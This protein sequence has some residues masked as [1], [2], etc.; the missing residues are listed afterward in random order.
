MNWAVYCRFN[1]ARSIISSAVLRNLYPEATVISGGIQAGA[2][3]PIPS[4]VAAIA[5]VWGLKEFDRSSAL[6][7]HNWIEDKKPMVLVADALVMEEISRSVTPGQL[8]MLADFADH[9]FLVPI[10]PTGLEIDDLALE[11]SKVVVLTLRWALKQSRT[12]VQV[13]SHLVF[14][15][16][17]STNELGANDLADYEVL[18]DSNISRPQKKSWYSDREIIHFNP[19]NLNQT[20]FESIKDKSNIV[21]ASKFEID[22]CES[23]YLSR[24]W[25]NFLYEIAKVKSVTIVADGQSNPHVPIAASVLAISHSTDSYIW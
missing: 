3:S 6:V 12:N 13:S 18:I 14:S 8:S 19:R 1:Q 11:L 4:S 16:E 15:K 23:F 9:P 2:G 21:L 20:D 25:R 5:N 24:S 22:E 7:N 10:D 17:S